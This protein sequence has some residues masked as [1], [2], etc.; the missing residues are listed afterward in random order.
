MFSKKTLPIW[1]GLTA[2]FVALFALVIIGTG[3]AEAN[4]GTV[5]EALG[6]NT[7]T[8]VTETV[9]GEDLFTYKSDYTTAKDMVEENKK[10]AERVAANGSVFSKI[11]RMRFLSN[12]PP[13]RKSPWSEK[14]LIPTYWADKW[15]PVRQIT[16]K[17]Q[18]T[19]ETRQ[20]A[21]NSSIIRK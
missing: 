10:F 11:P 1:R 7:F 19:A 20:S 16:P 6:T 2:V 15:V 12:P 14:P 3:I 4:I 9:E 21:K 13:T 18:R 17:R 5:D 8:T